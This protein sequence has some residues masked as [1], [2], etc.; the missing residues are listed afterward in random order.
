VCRLDRKLVVKLAVLRKI[1]SVCKFRVGRRWMGFVLSRK[2]RESLPSSL[3]LFR[4]L[5]YL[6][7]Q[8]LDWTEFIFI[9]LSTD[10]FFPP[11]SLAHFRV[12]TVPEI[13][14]HTDIYKEGSII[15]GA[16]AVMDTVYYSQ[17]GHVS[18]CINWRTNIVCLFL[19]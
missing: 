13:R 5:R 8:Q 3:S 9:C 18:D 14:L 2:K 10:F 17:S 7:A 6:C 19:C 12:S 4:A 15:T 16:P 11:P 1:Q